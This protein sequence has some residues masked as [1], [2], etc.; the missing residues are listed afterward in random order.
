LAGIS[1]PVLPPAKLI[2][3][4]RRAFTNEAIPLGISL[5]GGAGEELALL[6]GLVAGTRISAG[7]P[8][9]GTGWRLAAR[10]LTQALAYAPKDFVGVME[11]TVDLRA[12]NDV[13]AD[14]RSI[15]LEWLAK[16][17][18]ESR[19]APR[20]DRNDSVPAA[21]PSLDAEEIATLMRRGQEYLKIGDI[22]AARLVLRRAA[23]A[24]SPQ[25][26]LT[27]GSTFE[28]LVLGELGA[29]GFLPDLDQA[30]SWYDKAARLGSP[31]ASRRIEALA[32]ADR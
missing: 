14:R 12:A 4:D 32:R 2:L 23:N 29:H 17:V 10:D 8:S 15:R 25:A 1:V 26:A 22:A 31:E 19:R 28:P 13:L 7:G 6:S 9:G 27:L 24:G 5:E 3:E 11:A 18:D 20:L 30:R 16:Q 21:A